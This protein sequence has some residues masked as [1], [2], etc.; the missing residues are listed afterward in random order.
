[1][2]KTLR[3][4]I[5]TL[6]SLLTL[7]MLVGCD[8]TAPEQPKTQYRI[9]NEKYVEEIA[10]NPEYTAL[11]FEL[12]SLPIYYKVLKALPAG[13]RALR[14]LQNSKVQCRYSLRLISGEMPEQ[15]ELLDSWIYRQ[16]GTRYPDALVRGMQLALQHMAV[17]E[18][19][20]VV[21][22]WQMGYGAYSQTA[23]PA[24]STLIFEIEL[25]SITTL[26]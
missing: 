22:P 3:A 26:H 18:K 1:M 4:L 16:V 24:Y 8:Q 10:K 19:W 14:P 15:D 5:L 25:L 20:E 2:R 21:I 12:S 13:E 23:I 9:D 7:G 6:T 11:S 17:G